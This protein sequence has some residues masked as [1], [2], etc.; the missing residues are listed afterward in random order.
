MKSTACQNITDLHRETNRQP[1]LPVHLFRDNT[2]LPTAY[3]QTLQMMATYD[4][5][6]QSGRA[7]G[8]LPAAYQAYWMDG[9]APHHEICHLIDL[10]ATAKDVDGDKEAKKNVERPQKYGE[11]ETASS[12]EVATEV[13]NDARQ[14]KNK[15]L[16]SQEKLTAELQEEKKKNK[17]LRAEMEKLMADAKEIRWMYATDV[18]T[19]RQLADRLQQKLQ[20]EVKSHEDRV[21]QD[22]LLVQTLRDEQD[23]LRRQMAEQIGLLQQNASERETVLREE[24]ERLRTQLIVEISL[25][26]ELKEF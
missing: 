16:Q 17:V 13:R 22:E 26:R 20:K 2:E 5:M 15:D 1:M 8:Q 12:A 4:S 24:M 9:H 14:V 10:L 6:H 18:V 21:S 3:S 11:A 7:V 23:A 25:N 19:V